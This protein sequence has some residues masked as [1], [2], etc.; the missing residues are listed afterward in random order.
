MSASTLI[1]RVAARLLAAQIPDGS[2]ESGGTARFIID[3]LTAEQAAAIA[4]A[5]LGER[6]LA[7]QIEIK[8]P[9]GLV[10]GQD[11]PESILTTERATYFRN[12]PSEK[13]ILLVANTGDDEEQSLKELVPIGAAQLQDRPDLW[14]AIAAEG[15][16]LTSDHLKWWEKALTGIRDLRLF[17]LER[18]A[19]YILRTRRA[20][21]EE[22]LPII[23][24]LGNSL[25][26]LHIPKDSAY[27][28]ALNAKTAGHASKWRRLLE[29]AQKKRAC[30]LQKQTP[31][32]TLLSEEELLDTFE[33]VKDSIPDSIHSIVKSFIAAA[34]GW[35]DRS[36]ALAECEWE[37]IAPLFDGFKRDAF[38]LGQATL[39]FYDERENDLITDDEREYLNRLIKRKT[40]GSE[41]DEDRGFFENHR[42]ELK[43]DRKLKLAWDRFIF[44]KPLETDEL[45]AGLVL[46]L[47]RLFGHETPMHERQLR[48][49]C[50]RATKKDL[51]DLNVDAGIYF[52]KRYKGLRTLFGKKVKW[53][54]GHLFDFP[55]LVQGWKDARKP[56]NY[57]AA[58]AALQLKFILELEVDV[59]P[60]RTEVTATQLI[61]KF[62]QQTVAVGFAQDWSRIEE[63]PLA[64]CST[65]RRPLST[66]AQ[67]QTVDLSNVQSFVPA[68]GKER[69][70]FVGVYKASEDIERIWR[71]HLAD[72]RSRNF[73]NA[74]TSQAL[75][76]HFDAFLAAYT[77][78]VQA[79][80]SGD[81]A[82]GLASASLFQQAQAYSTLLEFICRQAS[83]D[84]NR[85]LLLRPLL[86]IGVIAV[87]GGQCCAITA[88]WQ[89]LRMVASAVKA[90]LV[91]SLIKRLLE[92]TQVEFGDSRLFFRDLHEALR[93][94][95]YPEIVL[96][97]HEQ[98][99]EL[100][101]LTDTMGDYSLHESPVVA[102]DAYDDMNEN[103]T[104]AANCVVDLVRR[105]LDLH[106]HEHANLAIV[107]Y[108]CDSAR[109]PQ[110]V[111]E[112]IAAMYDE[113]EEVRCQII[114][115]HRDVTRLRALYERILS[116][117]DE[118]PD[119]FSAS[120]ATRDFM[121]R[122]RI[123]IMADQAPVPASDGAR[124]TDIVFSE[125]VIARQARLEWYREG[126][127]PV[128]M[129]RLIPPHWS[130]RR[131]TALDDM[132]SVVYLCCPAQ[133]PEG[134]AFLTAL[135]TF[136]EGDWD[137]GTETR[138]LPARQLDFRDTTTARIFDETHNL[139]N[140]VVNYDE[141]LDRRQLLN[142]DVRIIR[143]RQVATQGRNIIIS[144]KAPLGLL[145]AMVLGRLRDLNLN[146][147]DNEY[148]DLADQFLE[149]AKEISGDIVLRAAKHG[150]NASELI[151]IVLSRFLLSH[152][153]GRDATLGWYFL[154]DYSDW[155]GQREEQIADIL[156]LSLE[157]ADGALRL[158]VLVAEAKYIDEGNLA[159]K[160]RESQR[161]LRDTVR[162][163]TDAV[164]GSPERL[165]RTLWLARLSDLILD[166]V[167]VSG[168]KGAKL[169]EWRRAIREGECEIF[170]RGYS[171][172]FVSSP[173]DATDCAD[174][175]NVA[176][177]DNGF[178][179][180]FSRRQLKEIVLKYLAKQNPTSIREE[181][182]GI[183]F[184]SRR[185]YRRPSDLKSVTI[186]IP[187]DTTKPEDSRKTDRVPVA[188]SVSE[189]KAPETLTQSESAIES[190]RAAVGAGSRWAY[191]GIEALLISP[192]TSL[193]ES[194]QDR[195][196]LK[197]IGSRTKGALQQ[198][199]LQSKLAESVLTPNAA[200]LRFAGSA[201]LTV[202]QVLKRRS[203]FLTTHGI[204]IISVSPAPG[205]VCI[206][207]ER[208]RRQLVRIQD[209]WNRWTPNSL[210][211]NQELLIG[212]REDNGE[213]LCISP[214]E[215]HAPH[216][217]VA[218]ST[219]SGKSV[220]LQN[221]LLAI[222]ATN[223]PRHARIT[224]IDP[225]QG[226]DYVQFEG[227]PH[228]EGGVI[229]D[230]AQALVRLREL[231]DEMDRR[232]ALFKGTRTNSLGP[233]NRK[234]P[235]SDRLPVLWIFHDEFAEWMLVEDYK[236]HV[237]A[238]VSR[239]GVK[240]RAAGIHLVFAAQRPDANVM[241]MQLRA[242]LG[243]RLILR[244]DSEG[245]S[246]IAL[247]D[248]G[249]ERLL[250]RGHMLAKL[251]GFPLA[252]VQVP[253]VDPDFIDQV[254]TV[255][256]DS[257]P[258][259]YKV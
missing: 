188:P 192:S 184:W 123:G 88:P 249:A 227:L 4:R 250:G 45:L 12:A 3:C 76:E 150:R 259:Q 104:D 167:Q 83:G 8:L 171:H 149:D 32:L 29:T 153:L 116:A 39:D 193:D 75:Q 180:V 44:G 59:A 54:V 102:N 10:Q 234:V 190:P 232:Y 206:G 244:V 175:A 204:N 93:H 179:E 16:S 48:I 173:S 73:V 218:G 65:Q 199:Q 198:F 40:S 246:E 231:V 161:Q 37:S 36:A 211:G 165:D 127:K 33:R 72:A 201:N 236:E 98:Q 138:L 172:I 223:T 87:A 134:W 113:E 46:C 187:R 156:A 177:L 58:R 248:S 212:I 195:E 215:L 9:I 240:A 181:N 146:L 256:R 20:I 137:G 119:V 197:E 30:F 74:E 67:F 52:A 142:H 51:R 92:P 26:A 139:G 25:P 237:T 82:N 61:W 243:N 222:V 14:V 60:G 220:L 208:P 202:D 17:S 15:L 68:F 189:E 194:A 53:D 78:A 143:Y 79:F 18:V 70:S 245:T 108:N 253:Y 183:E 85:E 224:L 105:Y 1:G 238:L 182:A 203:E 176:D 219:G 69:G 130:R 221:L 135:T 22:G 210:L 252:Y 34:P 107:L 23:P 24:A 148:Q 121:A 63:H 170:V 124:P 50:E 159:S 86:Q 64:F 251:E 96:G 27:F 95:F 55:E 13:P 160:R 140:W 100:L 205:L 125:D 42:N 71:E 151:G 196:W 239:L 230:Q 62:A 35:N 11:L 114:L 43:E 141:L 94:P 19:D 200:L 229:D 178:Q 28:N 90:R 129:D 109:L 84:R 66:K 166:G 2:E 144:S 117:S 209:V 233:Y 126:A 132:K 47:E 226:V 186:T 57:S 214:G 207:I 228:L 258:E 163:V 217:L 101:I 191:P 154:D 133:S 145:R 242:N 257:E 80:G 255:I 99:P 155:L 97:W 235:E 164:F 21:E 49:R 168:T 216:T 56:L 122:L 118:D 213:L 77:S 111:V 136:V 106:P 7:S 5:I 89:P 241:P 120:E 112:K 103:P 6:S 41:E 38:N 110:A 157:E 81:E 152:E 254:V 174:F 225:K 91:A 131:P 247:G 128:T 169:I 115:R 31:S 147:Q 185:T 158:A 162:R